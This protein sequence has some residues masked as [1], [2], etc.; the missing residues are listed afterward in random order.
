MCFCYMSNYIS[1][2][3][4]IILYVISFILYC[5][6]LATYYKLYS[7]SYILYILLKWTLGAEGFQLGPNY[8]MCVAAAMWSKGPLSL[9]ESA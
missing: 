4:C 6:L 5:T 3:I 9:C 7:V 2:M 1:T 8:N